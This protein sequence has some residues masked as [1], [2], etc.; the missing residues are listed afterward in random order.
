M[1][2][3]R[4]E[5]SVFISCPSAASDHAATLFTLQTMHFGTQTPATCAT[6]VVAHRPP[7]AEAA[8]PML[9]RRRVRSFAAELRHRTKARAAHAAPLRRL[10]LV[11]RERR[12]TAV[13]LRHRTKARAAHTAPLRRRHLVQRERRFAAVKLRRRSLARAA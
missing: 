7:A 6:C 5:T 9:K 1:N 12:F 4:C 3:C 10:H 2:A 8:S 11:Q 13:K